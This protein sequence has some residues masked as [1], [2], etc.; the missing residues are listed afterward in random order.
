VLFVSSTISPP[1]PMPNVRDDRETPLCVG[2][3]GA[4]YSFDLGTVRTEMFLQTRLDRANQIDLIQE[5]R[6]NAQGKIGPPIRRTVSF[7]RVHE[8][9]SSVES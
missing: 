8:K 3:D 7:R 9:L 6:M 5:F 1:H 2:Q 4:V